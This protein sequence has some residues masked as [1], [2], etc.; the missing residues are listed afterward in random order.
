M[1]AYTVTKTNGF[2]NPKLKKT[3]INVTNTFCEGCG[4]GFIGVVISSP[5]KH[6]IKQ[7]VKVDGRHKELNLHAKFIKSG[8]MI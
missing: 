5:H 7:S 8:K 2:C 6:L 3:L 1:L 4:R